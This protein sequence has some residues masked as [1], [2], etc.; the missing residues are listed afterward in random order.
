M[1]YLPW[2]LHVQKTAY[3]TDRGLY[4]A[5]Y[6]L[7][8]QRLEATLRSLLLLKDPVAASSTDVSSLT[9]RSVDPYR[10]AGLW[11]TG[12]PSSHWVAPSCSTQ[13]AR[14]MRSIMKSV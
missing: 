9:K 4:L 13:T 10:P 11:T 7:L 2:R 6:P 1:P 8:S 14:S 5:P 3:N 12:E